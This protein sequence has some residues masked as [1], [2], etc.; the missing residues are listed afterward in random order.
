MESQIVRPE[1]L[2]LQVYRYLKNQVLTGALNPGERV[3]ETRI[4]ADLSTSR[5]PVR[6]A[7]Q[8]LESEGLI[9]EVDGILQV[10]NPSLHDFRELYELR[11]ALE[12]EAARMAATRITDSVLSDLKANIEETRQ[13]IAAG[14]NEQLIPLNSRF[15]SLVLQAAGNKRIIQARENIEAL[16]NYYSY[17]IFRKN[18]M[19]TNIVQEHTDVY[20]ALRDGY[21]QQAYEAMYGHIQI[22][23]TIVEPLY[24]Q[25]KTLQ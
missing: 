20:M 6:E 11:L 19:Q 3:V 15:H 14:E 17:M 8:M 21:P 16:I 2:A 9:V 23:L 22:D 7:L 10:F 25:N 4:A 18:N 12:A 1:S 24:E 13:C 5:S